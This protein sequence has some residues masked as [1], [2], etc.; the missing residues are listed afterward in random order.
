MAILFFLIC[1]FSIVQQLS[2]SAG[3]QNLFSSVGEYERI[4]AELAIK[5]CLLGWLEICIFKTVKH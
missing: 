2:D 5:I 1:K 4:H 3:R